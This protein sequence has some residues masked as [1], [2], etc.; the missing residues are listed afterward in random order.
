MRLCRASCH[1]W[2]S[3]SPILQEHRGTQ[4]LGAW[5][6]N[7]CPVRVP[8]V[9]G[10]QQPLRGVQQRGWTSPG[11]VLMLEVCKP[12]TRCDTCFPPTARELQGIRGCEEPVEAHEAGRGEAS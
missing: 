7:Q 11:Q 12:S 3:T 9:P 2:G 5:R 8:G 4:H 1:G 6:C 10:S